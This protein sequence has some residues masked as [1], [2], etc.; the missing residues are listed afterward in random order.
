MKVTNRYEFMEKIGRRVSKGE[1]ERRCRSYAVHQHNKLQVVDYERNEDGTIK[2]GAD[3]KPTPRV[4]RAYTIVIAPD[5]PKHERKVPMSERFM[6]GGKRERF[7]PRQ[8]HDGVISNQDFS[9]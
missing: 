1:W 2:M 9:V 8:Q 6:P 4:Q 7:A 3:G 5:T